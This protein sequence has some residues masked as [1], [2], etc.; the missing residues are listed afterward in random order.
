MASQ[1]ARTLKELAERL[2]VSI[3]TVS[4]ALAGHEQIALKTRQ[5]VS[6]A[7]RE[8][9]YVP[10]VAARQLVSGRSNFVGFIIPLRGP[11]FMDSY[12][13]EFVTGLGEGFVAHGIDLILATVQPNRS[14]LDVLRH[15]VES[16]RADGVV[17]PRIAADDAR[18]DY[19][20]ATGFPFVAHGRIRDDEGDYT[21]LDADSEAAFEEAFDLLYSHGHRH[22]GLVSIAEDMTFR[23][24]REKGLANA[25]A[26]KGDPTV[27]LDIV[28]PPRFD[29]GASVAAINSLLGA[30]E[31]PTAIIGL[32]DE[33]ALTVMEE[34][35]R[36]GLSIPRDLSVMGFDNIST[37][38]YAPPGLTT[39]EVKTRGMAREIAHML[40]ALIE[41]EEPGHSN[42]LIKPSLV[43]RASHGPVPDING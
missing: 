29:R 11:N 6:E 1:R 22:I 2:G 37:A 42:R 12:L 35:Q 4:R 19:L 16:G 39:F 25:I 41:G 32:F 3:T 7:A 21:W 10:N 8:M 24:L 17:V 33:L 15:L 38:A 30:T 31:R 40:V 14:E 9:G 28:R 18:I 34:A 20:R 26:R 23:N 13:G 27:R 43:L 36:A 5:R